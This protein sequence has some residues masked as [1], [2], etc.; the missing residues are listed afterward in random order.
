MANNSI[1]VAR[2][3]G[4]GLLLLTLCITCFG[5][6][7][8]THDPISQDLLA[9][10][11]PPGSGGHWLGTDHYGR[12][13]LSRLVHGSR[14]SIGLS[15]LTVAC[16]AVPGMLLGIVAAWRGGWLDRSLGYLTD[17]MMALPGL[18]LVLLVMAFAPGQALTLFLGLSL[19]LWVEFF[20]VSRSMTRTSLATSQVEAVRRLG[21]RPL[22]V[23]RRI[24]LPHLLPQMALLAG[25]AITT[26]IVAI[27]TLSA[28]SVGLQPPTAELGTLIAEAMPYYADA[29][30]LVL[31]PSLVILMFV[32]SIQLL[33]GE[34]PHE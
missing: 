11:L 30:W 31:A 34:R 24:V 8:L 16:A 32:L 14:L 29:P 1:T 17:T 20:R 27:A 19:T 22:Y 18:L 28:I 33:S 4:W 25:F 15:L 21:F 3:L 2:L 26:A 10:L 12:D 13:V 9:I 6:L 23:L 7:W 5:P